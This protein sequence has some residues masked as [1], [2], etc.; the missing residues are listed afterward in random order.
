[1]YACIGRI[2]RLGPCP[3]SLKIA[4]F[5]AY[6]RPVMMYSMYCAEALPYTK[7]QAAALDS[8]QL[9]YIRWSLGQLS[10]SSSCTDSLAEVGQ[11]PVSYDVTRARINYYL[12]VKSRPQTHITVAPLHEAMTTSRKQGNWWLRVK[13]DMAD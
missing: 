5:N 11:K 6:V 2:H 8:L 13:Q 9:Q 10:R 7:T 12:L 1:M 3:V 4:L